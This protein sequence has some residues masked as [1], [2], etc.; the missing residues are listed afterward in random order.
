MSVTWL[1]SYPKSGNTWVRALL[2]PFLEGGDKEL[3]VDRIGCDASPRFRNALDWRLAVDCSL[4]RLDE[5]EEYH[6]ELSLQL[7]RSRAGVPAAVKVHS[8]NTRNRDGVLLFPPEA[9]SVV[10]IVRNPLDVAASVAPFFDWTIERTAEVMADES[11]I[12]NDVPDRPSTMLPERLLSWS[13]HVRSW[14]DGGGPPVHLVRYEDLHSDTEA[15]LNGILRFMGLTPDAARVRRA[16]EETGFDRLQSQEAQ[17]GFPQH[18][19]T[20]RA[21]FF[22]RGKAGGWREEVPSEVALRLVQDHRDMMLRL[23][24]GD[25]VADVES[26][27]AAV[28]VEP[29]A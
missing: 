11:Y 20:A 24:Y 1:A 9:G 25:A 8:A 6:P 4:M 10:Y 22:R 16:V 15:S 26:Q 28:P 3:A 29:C 23:G 13:G 19:P 12:L 18:S 7:C 5:V 21:P 2:T 27:A 14:L 17:T